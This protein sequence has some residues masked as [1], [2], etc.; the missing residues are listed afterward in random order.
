MVQQS[1]EGCGTFKTLQRGQK[2]INFLLLI[3]EGERGKEKVKKKKIH[4]KPNLA[5]LFTLLGS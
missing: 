3:L 5:S 4:T 2:I 1:R